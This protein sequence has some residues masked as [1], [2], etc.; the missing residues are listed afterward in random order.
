MRRWGAGTQLV[1]LAIAEMVAMRADEV[2]LEAEVT[3]QGALAL[4]HNLGFLRDKRLIRHAPARSAAAAFCCA[5]M[6]IDS[7]WVAA[8]CC[9][10]ILCR[11]P[12]STCATRYRRPPSACNCSDSAAEA[13]RL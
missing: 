9:I 4:Y 10:R 11:A 1:K 3:N 12:L 8:K 13:G 5:C 6:A 7:W 2:V